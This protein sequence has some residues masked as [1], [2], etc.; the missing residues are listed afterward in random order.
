M[1]GPTRELTHEP[2]NRD[3]TTGACCE[4]ELNWTPRFG[5]PHRGM[6]I[7]RHITEMGDALDHP[8]AEDR[9]VEMHY[10]HALFLTL[11]RGIPLIK[12]I[13]LILVLAVGLIWA[14]ASFLFNLW[15]KG[16]SVDELTKSLKPAFTNAGIAQAQKDVTTV[17]GVVNELKGTTLPFLVKT[18][19]PQD[20]PVVVAGA[21]PAVGVALGTNDPYGKPYA[22][23][24]IYLDHAA[25]YLSFV[26][27]SLK[28][29]QGNFADAQAIPTK[30]IGT[31]GLAALFL[32]LG[33]V[34]LIVG[35]LLFSKPGLGRPLAILTAVLGVVVIVVTYV[36]NVPGKTQSVDDLTNAFRP[37]FTTSATPLSIATAQKYLDGVTAADAELRSTL[38]D[39]LSD[40]IQPKLTKDQIATTLTQVSP[41]VANALYGKDSVDTK[42]T[43]LVG[44]LDRF[45][46]LAAKVKKGIPQFK[47]AD[48]LPGI[49]WP[50]TSVQVLFVVPAILLILCGIGL[51]LPGGKKVET[52]IQPVARGRAPAR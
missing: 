47:D 6:R 30:D 39:R 11:N 42:V 5:G 41:K 33:V 29:Q 51:A 37:V 38:L 25:D 50:T 43:P 22:D 48:N 44:I 31:I 9:S 35:W 26:A 34:I 16:A 52:S 49:G 8:A 32:A 18:L 36:L 19:A 40:L 12:K 3:K 46:A 2:A 21:F 20:V 24:R 1:A 13:S 4:P 27:T 10:A 7:R 15:G 28:S 45:D 23:H 17:K 14:A